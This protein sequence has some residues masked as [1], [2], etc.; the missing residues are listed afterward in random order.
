MTLP[1]GW[2]CGS[3][4]GGSAFGRF[5]LKPEP[6]LNGAPHLGKEICCSPPKQKRLGQ[7][8]TEFRCCDT[9]LRSVGGLAADGYDGGSVAFGFDGAYAV[10]LQEGGDG[11]RT[12]DDDGFEGCVGEDEEGGLAGCRGF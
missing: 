8:T 7:A 3:M 4:N 11:A 5:P 9:D 2:G 1:C 10:D 6:G 12:G